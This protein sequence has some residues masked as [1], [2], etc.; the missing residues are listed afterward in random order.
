MVNNS[1]QLYTIEGITAAVI[2]LVTA[3]IVLNTTTLYTPADTHVTDMQL[4]QLG[5]DALAMMDTADRPTPSTFS[6]EYKKSPLETYIN[7]SR[8]KDNLTAIPILIGFN[9]DFNNYIN[10]LNDFDPNATMVRTDRRPIQW[11]AKVY[12]RGK[13]GIGNYSFDDS[14]SRWDGKAMTGKE[15][16]VR[17]T[18]LVHIQG[19]PPS[20]PL[21]T[22][23]S[24]MHPISADG[25]P[26][27]WDQVVLLEV[28]LWRD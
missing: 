19:K 11:S 14:S 5:N 17:V 22:I 13:N 27:K 15:H 7:E 1:G 20:T 25:E 8:N 26:D 2:M 23:P 21:V 24:D 9:T 12:Y 4:E 28:L 18:R 10:Y 16:F 6:Y 3:Y